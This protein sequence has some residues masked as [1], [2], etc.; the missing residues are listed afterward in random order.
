[1]TTKTLNHYLIHIKLLKIKFLNIIKNL[2]LLNLPKN[3]HFKRNKKNYHAQ[4]GHKSL[5]S[6]TY[7]TQLR[8]NLKIQRGYRKKKRPHAFAREAVF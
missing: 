7:K 2:I 1:M 4:S 5:H 8:Q 6:A 3:N